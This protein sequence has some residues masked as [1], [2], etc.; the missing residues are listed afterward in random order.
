MA[1][2]IK[3][4]WTLHLGY[5]SAVSY[6]F[7]VLP[8]LSSGDGATGPVSQAHPGVGA[9]PGGLIQD[10]AVHAPLSAAS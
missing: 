8:Q 1:S 9:H 4:K 7:S 10:Q 6:P 2:L 5:Q 3:T